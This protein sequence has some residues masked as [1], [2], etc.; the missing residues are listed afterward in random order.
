[1][2]TSCAKGV[3]P[4]FAAFPPIG[5]G[6]V[7]AVPPEITFVVETKI[8]MPW[9]T[10]WKLALRRVP[11]SAS[12]A[13]CEAGPGIGN[14]KPDSEVTATPGRFCAG[15]LI[16]PAYAVFDFAITLVLKAEGKSS[17]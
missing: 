9:G 7:T 3:D 11:Y 17:E 15:L 4:V 12:P 5:E 2:L 1:M 6:G 10:F 16:C 13:T 14:T 8:R